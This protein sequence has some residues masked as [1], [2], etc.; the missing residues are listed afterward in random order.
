MRVPL[1]VYSLPDP[2]S[3]PLHSLT[4]PAVFFNLCN[5]YLMGSYL[6]GRT[7]PLTSRAG[8]VPS[9][10]LSS[11]VFWAGISLFLLGF[12]GNILSDEI[13]Y[14]LR[15]PDPAEGGKPKPRYSIPRGF[16]YDSPAGGISFPAYF[17]EWVEWLGFAVAATAHAAAPA[18][19]SLIPGTAEAAGRFADVTAAGATKLPMRLFE[20][21]TFI[22][23]P[24]L[25]LYAEI[26]SESPSPR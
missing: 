20:S 11:P 23:P 10:A 9:S 7:S 22:T 2:L 17:C 19:P 25:F 8:L 14:S 26:A 4:F 13:L 6:G 18:M 12:A 21:N 24:F 1:G 15:R 16:L 5:G 3:L